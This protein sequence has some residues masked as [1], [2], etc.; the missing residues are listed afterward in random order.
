MVK[1]LM[2]LNTPLCPVRAAPRS[3]A[4]LHINLLSYAD[5]CDADRGRRPVQAALP[6]ADRKTRDCRSDIADEENGGEDQ[7]FLDMHSRECACV[8]GARAFKTPSG[9][10]CYKIGGARLYSRVRKYPNG[11]KTT[12][13]FRRPLR[14][15]IGAPKVGTASPGTTIALDIA[16]FQFSQGRISLTLS[17]RTAVRREQRW[18]SSQGF[19]AQAAGCASKEA[20]HDKQEEPAGLASAAAECA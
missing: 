13:K 11:A 3:N 10:S 4:R 8:L 6:V 16:H 2:A 14:Q 19:L 1:N 17:S 12:N 5:A 9:A 18:S 20:N 15:P 7:A